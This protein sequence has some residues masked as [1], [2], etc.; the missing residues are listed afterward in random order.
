MSFFPLFFFSQKLSSLISVCLIG[1]PSSNEVWGA[2]LVLSA[3][4]I[5]LWIPIWLRV[6]LFFKGGD[7]KKVLLKK[8]K[9]KKKLSFGQLPAVIGRT[10]S[11]GNESAVFQREREKERC[12][13]TKGPA[14][15]ECHSHELMLLATVLTRS[16]IASWGTRFF[17]KSQRDAA[18]TQPLRITDVRV[19]SW[20]LSSPVLCR[21][22]PPAYKWKTRKYVS[23][24]K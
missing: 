12:E 7:I 2:H 16:L 21:L 8:K 23:S 18:G 19:P 13:R 5:F 1:I 24:L 14:V 3:A 11:Y 15:I 4:W 22:S 9:S 6:I 17:T 20:A 10:I